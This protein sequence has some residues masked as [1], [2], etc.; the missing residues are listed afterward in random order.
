VAGSVRRAASDELTR[1][2]VAGLRRLMA[3]AFQGDEAFTDEDWE[4]ATGGLH[5]VL[6]EDGEI[7]SHG[8]VVERELHTGGYNLRTGYV[9]AVATRPDRQRM[10]HGSTVMREIGDHI[11]RSFDLGALGTGAFAFYERLGW[12]R[13]RGPTFVRKGSE[14]IPTL[15]DD[16]YV[17]VRLTPRTPELDLDAPIS[18]LWRPGD[19]W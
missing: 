1:N 14:V 5:F 19:V 11:D 7:V 18:C 4:H 13:W 8:S 10:G 16:G 15:E 17:F 2:E 12:V 9:E 6:E 3:T